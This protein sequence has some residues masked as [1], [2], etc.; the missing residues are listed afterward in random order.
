MSNTG[1]ASHQPDFVNKDVG[2][3]DNEDDPSKDEFAN[4]GEVQQMVELEA[5]LKVRLFVL[6]IIVFCPFFLFVFG[7][8]FWADNRKRMQFPMDIG[9][10]FFFF[11]SENF[12]NSSSTNQI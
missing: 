10:F 1:H 12:F 3:P 7:F 5:E 11:K 6:L 4:A 2:L 9:C 8:G